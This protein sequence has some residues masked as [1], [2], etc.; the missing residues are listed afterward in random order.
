MVDTRVKT[1]FI[2]DND[3]GGFYSILKPPDRWRDVACRDDVRVTF[4][5][6]FDDRSMEGI[7][8]KRN[9]CIYG[10]DRSLERS[11][12]SDVKG[13]GRRVRKALRQC[14]CAFERA[15][16][17]V[18]FST[19]IYEGQVVTGPTNREFVRWITDYVLRRRAGDEATSEEKHFLSRL[20]QLIKSSSSTTDWR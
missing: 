15:T 10:C 9:N 16:S 20:I 19:W 6:S 7:R 14:F 4:D 8:D 3:A 1:D 13:Y 17:C 5:G 12:I 11:G 18:S 2:H